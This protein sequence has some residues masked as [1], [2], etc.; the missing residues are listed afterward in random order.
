MLVISDRLKV[1]LRE[2]KFTFVRSGGPG[3]QNVNKVATKAVL[4]WR[5]IDSASLPEPIRERIL[6]KNRRRISRDGDLILTS[7]R[8]RDQG[9]NVADC[10]AKL[11]QIVAD[12]ATVAKVRKPSR[13]TK[14]SRARRLDHKR[15]HAAK[16][17]LRKRPSQED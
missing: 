14:A 2:L 1:P 16:K 12:A 3:G 4:R 5:V 10:L 13:P 15:T 8:F 11:R 6:A 17:R 7:Q 9:R